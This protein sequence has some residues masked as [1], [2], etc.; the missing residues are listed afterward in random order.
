M[1]W[2]VMDGK[3]QPDHPQPWSPPHTQEDKVRVQSTQAAKHD[4]QTKGFASHLQ[5]AKHD[6]Q[7]MDFASRLQSSPDKHDPPN[8][9]KDKP[10]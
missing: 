5:T 6:C 10:K 9:K 3:K 7:T 4:G 2:S 8:Y 1:S